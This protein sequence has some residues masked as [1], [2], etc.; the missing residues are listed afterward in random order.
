M[1]A[2]TCPEVQAQLDL[3]AAGECDL[4]TRAG[5]EAHLRECPACAAVYAES[6][7]V[8]TLVRLH[9]DGD[10]IERLR[11]RIERESQQQRT[12]RRF[13]PFVKRTLVAA[14]VFL[15]CIGV[16]SWLPQTARFGSE[17]RLALLVHS[18]REALPPQVAAL[19]ERKLPAI[20]PGPTESLL[21]ALPAGRL[22]EA[23]RSELR[24]RS[25]GQLPPPPAVA[26]QLML[27]NK[28]TDAVTVRIGDAEP[29]LILDVQGEG[30]VRVPVRAAQAAAFLQPQ[31]RRLA[32]G[33]ATTFHVD[34]LV[35]GSRRHPEYVYLTEPG[36]FMLTARLQLNVDGHIESVTA[37]PVRITVVE[38]N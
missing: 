9:C 22:G 6:Q 14:A 26:F 13:L 28:G 38:K 34:R 35:A 10:A 3:L 33:E 5:L 4:P 24:Q 23:F 16:L 7:R 11:L 32:P 37:A 8:L 12:S 18:G 20:T 25:A 29:T 21:I 15:V 19:A 1:S 31:S 27:M 30:V 2:L 36:K 17:P